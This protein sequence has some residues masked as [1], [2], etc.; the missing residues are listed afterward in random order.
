M[1]SSSFIFWDC[2]KGNP[3]TTLQWLSTALKMKS[4]P[5]STA[6][7]AFHYQPFLRLLLLPCHAAIL[8]SLTTRQSHQLPI[9]LGI[10]SNTTLSERFSLTPLFNLS[11]L[12]EVTRA[13]SYYFLNLLQTL[14]QPVI[15]FVCFFSCQ[16]RM[17]VPWRWY[18]VYLIYSCIFTASTVPGT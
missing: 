13:L 12:M 10:S 5:L 6:Y 16:I 11:H 2:I 3:S 4:K 17:L 9:R 1:D 7:K 14:S 18:L 8:C 15:S